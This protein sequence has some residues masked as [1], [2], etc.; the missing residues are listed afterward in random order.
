[1]IKTRFD[2]TKQWITTFGE[3]FDIKEMETNHIFNIINMFERKPTM[4]QTFLIK[5][6]SNNWTL[7]KQGSLN[8]ITSL[9]I[10]ELKAY[11]YSCPL[12]I[13]MKTE[14]E[15]RGANVE[16]MMKNFKEEREQ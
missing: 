5:D 11:F 7:N 13:T 6:I 16:Q 1:M 4:I 3:S 14:L 10:E 9:T 8:N 15:K 12:F 2:E